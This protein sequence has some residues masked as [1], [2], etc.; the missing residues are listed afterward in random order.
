[1]PPE[2]MQGTTLPLPQGTSEVVEGKVPPET[3]DE[4]SLETRLQVKESGKNTIVPA[5]AWKRMKEE[6]VARGVRKAAVDQAERLKTLGYGSMEEL[7][8]AAASAKIK[9]PIS[10]KA[11]PSTD[12]ERDE[13]GKRDGKRDGKPQHG[14]KSNGGGRDQA[15]LEREHQAAV[16]ALEKEKRLRIRAEKSARLR[17]RELERTQVEIQL[18]GAAARA[19]VKD[20]DYAIHLL[21]REIEG[22]N[23][24]QLKGFDETKW[25]SSLRETTPLI[26]G[27]TVRPATT[28]TGITGHPPAPRP[29]HITGQDP[30]SAAIV[31]ANKLDQSGFQKLLRKMGL[32]SHGGV[33]A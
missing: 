21:R 6:Q 24:E 32:N 33:P 3:R 20:V 29:T 14:A 25:F 31:D 7:L 30:T 26:F 11:E 15:K 16:A 13:D 4:V 12:D 5:E 1:M 22:K 19:G 17:Q 28:G 10:S 18:R 9:T 27:E 2:E 23:P 8:A